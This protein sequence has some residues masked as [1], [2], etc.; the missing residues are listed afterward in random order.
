MAGRLQAQNTVGRNGAGKKPVADQ[1]G[2]ELPGGA[3][4]R[5]FGCKVKVEKINITD[6]ASVVSDG[7]ENFK[8]RHTNTSFLWRAYHSGEEKARIF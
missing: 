7:G 2:D 8:L 3:A 5:I 6:G 4:V 1:S